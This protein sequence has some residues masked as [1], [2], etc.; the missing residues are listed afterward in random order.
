[1][2]GAPLHGL[3]IG[4]RHFRYEWSDAGQLAEALEQ[5]NAREAACGISSEGGLFEYGS[6]EEIVANLKVLHAQTA[7]DAFVVGSVTRDAGP[8]RASLLAS[9]V[10]TRPRT[11]EGFHG[12]AE[13]AGWTVQEVIQRPFSFHVLMIKA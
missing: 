1:M 5:L 3:E 8:V 10:S 7:G 13:Q 12:L 9:R 4:F 2:A 11:M 6:D